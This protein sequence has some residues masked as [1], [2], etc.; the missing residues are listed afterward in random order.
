MLC[1]ICAVQIQPSKDVVYHADN[2]ASIRQCQLHHTDQEPIC[3]E[4]S[5]SSS[6][7]SMIYLMCEPFWLDYSTVWC[8]NPFGLITVQS[9]VWTLLT[10]LRY[11]LMS[12]PCW[13]DYSTAATNV[14]CVTMSTYYLHSV[15]ARDNRMSKWLAML[16]RTWGWLTQSTNPRT[17]LSCIWK[18]NERTA[19]ISQSFNLEV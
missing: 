2:M 7:I 17:F 19:R 6:G 3:P 14:R 8:V 13:L 16:L 18:L 9:D 10:W 11:S 1:R 4:I 5:R 15:W 12:E